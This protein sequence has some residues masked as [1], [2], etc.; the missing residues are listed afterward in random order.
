MSDP[1]T[2]APA[3][4]AP[5][6]SGDVLGSMTPD[7][8]A[9]WR[10]TGEVPISSVE[11]ETPD[12]ESTDDTQ[13]SSPATPVDRAA[14][15]GAS[16][17]PASEPGTPKK[18]NASTRKAEVAADVAELENLLKRRAELRQQMLDSDT[19][20]PSTPK[21]VSDPATTTPTLAEALSQPDVTQP[22]LSETKFW[23]Q[24]PDAT[25]G[26]YAGY[27][28][29]YKLQSR[30]HIR[31][32]EQ[33]RADRIRPYTEQLQ[34]K[35]AEQPDFWQK[36]DPRVLNL[37]PVDNLPPGVKPTLANVLA[38]E[39]ITSPRAMALIEHLSANADTLLPKLLALPHAA[40][41]IREVGRLESRFE[42][43]P[44]VPTAAPAASPVSLAPDPIPT[45]GQK[46][47]QPADELTDAI[48]NGDFARYRE[49]QNRKEMRSA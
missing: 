20:T 36:V 49:L 27:I 37:N 23:E 42:N 13:A 2:Q 10:L 35:L 47:K 15:T 25:V 40:A 34:K 8:R 29:E 7:A 11:S 4:P 18:N 43:S 1:L 46:A 31:S 32:Q 17:T 28:A 24:F 21:P 22:M 16:R 12:H 5:P 38:Q 45:L 6:A 3:P 44:S 26:D 30:D 9:S 39:I 41:V 14:Q 19:V 48:R 33:A